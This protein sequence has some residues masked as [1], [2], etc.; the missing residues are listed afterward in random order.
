MPNAKITVSEASKV[1]MFGVELMFRTKIKAAT[2]KQ[3]IDEYY[4][5]VEE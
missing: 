2:L 4:E 5:D 1:F 3:L